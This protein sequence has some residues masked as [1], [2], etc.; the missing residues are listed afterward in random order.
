LVI[1]FHRIISLKT[2]VLMEH[3]PA[4]GKILSRTMG[5]WWI[6]RVA[7]STIV[8]YPLSSWPN[9][10]VYFWLSGQLLCK[11]QRREHSRSY[12]TGVATP[13]SDCPLSQKYMIS[14]G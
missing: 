7:F 5:I 11:A 9:G 3:P 14:F 4:G 13:Q 2:L 6:Y 1:F 8:L 12:V 10:I